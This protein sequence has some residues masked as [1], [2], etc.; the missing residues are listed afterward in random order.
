MNKAN[1]LYR[2]YRFPAEIISHAVWLY[3]RFC[4]SFR[5]IEDLLAE[6]GIVVSYET[7]RSWCIKFGPAYARMIKK[8]R[9]TLGDTWYMDEVYIVTVRGERRYL[10][11]A[12]D[13]DGDVL[14]ILVQKRKDKSAAERFFMKL[15]KGQG[16]SAREIVTDKLPS[17]G[18]ARK[19]I[20]S[21]S[22]H[23]CDRYANNRAEVSHEHTRA[24][25]RLMRRF[26][27]PGQAQRFL[28]V[29]SQVHNLFRIGRH[30]LRAA[31]YRFLR[32]RSFE[33][34]QQV[35]CAY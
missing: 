31:N 16:R 15:M 33:T 13:Q 8:R 11:R 7:I 27:S 3:H 6:R 26:K 4:L 10:W 14:D 35:T 25:E 32:N 24:Q 29:H 2:G 5:D 20:M 18:A 30:L 21:T 28:A 34:W 1:Q 17:Y 19:A 12:V 9:G 23:C 22:M